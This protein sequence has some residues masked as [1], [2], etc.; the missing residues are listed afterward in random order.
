MSPARLAIGVLRDPVNLL[1]TGFGVG[2]VP[3]APGTWGT[4][5]ALI[6]CWYMLALA[7]PVKLAAAAAALV[8][9][10]WLCGESARR[11]GQHDHPA[12]V[13][14]EIAAMLLLT[15]A[16]PR[17]AVWLLLAFALFRFFD[18]VKP[19]PI[20]DLDHRLPGGLGIMLDDQMAAV[21]SAACLGIIRYIAATT[22]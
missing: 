14:D 11:L 2:L 3:Y 22:Q 10:I 8:L 20:R 6:P 17:G 7:W 9:G 12:I 19:W 15:L 1:A 13:F 16:I 18:V 4:A 5:L 21:Y